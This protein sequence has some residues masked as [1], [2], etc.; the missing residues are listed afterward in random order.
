MSR[1][2]LEHTRLLD[3]RALRSISHPPN[4]LVNLLKRLIAIR[5]ELAHLTVI[6][7]HRDLFFMMSLEQGGMLFNDLH[8]VS[9][10]KPGRGVSG[11][12]QTRKSFHRPL[13]KEAIDLIVGQLKAEIS[14][15][16]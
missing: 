6:G 5:F 9:P 14:R 15:Q 7:V 8:L 1:Q 12:Y 2:R 13:F 11:Q 3:G 16:P 4:S 10:H